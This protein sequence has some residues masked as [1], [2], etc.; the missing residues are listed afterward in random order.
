MA[1]E[2]GTWGVTEVVV[3]YV[4]GDETWEVSLD[5]KHVDALVFNWDRFKAINKVVGRPLE[6]GHHVR[7]DGRL[8]YGNEPADEV[9]RRMGLKGPP[10]KLGPRQA[11]T[12]DEP[13]CFHNSSCVWW[14]MDETHNHDGDDSGGGG[15]PE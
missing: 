9:A 15:G 11:G 2:R 3:R 12:T 8:M 6:K 1:R 10:K 7:P 5:P 4:A 13:A 14:C